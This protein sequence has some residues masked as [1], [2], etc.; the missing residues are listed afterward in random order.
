M[1]Q[2]RGISLCKRS[3]AWVDRSSPSTTAW[4]IFNR[5]SSRMLTVTVASCCRMGRPQLPAKACERP[6]IHD[7]DGH[8]YLARSGHLYLATICTLRI[9]YIM[10]NY[11]FCTGL[12]A[13]SSSWAQS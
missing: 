13:C 8:L 2:R 3:A 10:V 9:M 12:E 11:V 6:P 1:V 4:M 5:S 7:P